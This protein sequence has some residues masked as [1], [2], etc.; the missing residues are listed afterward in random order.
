MLCP[1]IQRQTFQITGIIV[2]AVLILASVAEAQLP[3]LADTSLK[4]IPADASIYSISLR[5]E[6]TYQRLIESRAYAGLMQMP[7]VVQL[8]EQAEELLANPIAQG[9]MAD[10]ANK[11]LLALLSRLYGKESFFY[12]DQSYADLMGL[13]RD[14][15]LANSMVPIRMLAATSA[16]EKP[17]RSMQFAA[18]FR[19]AASNSDRLK[20]PNI[21]C[22]F[23]LSE[24]DVE[25]A[26]AQL[27]RLEVIGGL[28]LSGNEMLAGRLKAETVA[29]G[30]FITLSLDGS[31]LPWEEIPWDQFGAK[32]E[33]LDKLKKALREATLRVAIGVKDDYLMI[34][35]GSDMQHVEKLGK[36]DLLIDRPEFKRLTPFTDW[37]IVS[38]GYVGS[39]MMN[40][41]LMTKDYFQK[42]T[43]EVAAVLP[44]KMDP[45]LRKEI[46]K[47]IAAVEQ[48]VTEYLP[49]AGAVLGIGWS[50]AQ[51]YEGRKFNWSKNNVIVGDEPLSILSYVRGD[52]IWALTA[53]ERRTG[54]ELKMLNLFLSIAK[55]YGSKAIEMNLKGEDL[56]VYQE[57]Q[58]GADPLWQRFLRAN[59]NHLTA[60]MGTGEGAILLDAD[61]A[62][63]QW[64][65]LMP[66]AD[67][68]LPMFELAMLMEIS[69]RDGFVRGCEEYT[70]ICSDFLA[71][72]HN[73]EPDDFPEIT[74]PEPARKDL[75]EAGELYIYAAPEAWGLDEQIDT[76]LGNRRGPDNIVPGSS[77]THLEKDFAP[78]GLCGRRSRRTCSDGGRVSLG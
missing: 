66:P 60:V 64:L 75:D 18:L 54:G 26:T 23:K 16:G 78:N 49:E 72:L 35:I 1:K 41:I 2:S 33:D 32:V 8:K 31:M 74:F 62:S 29:G 69:D 9:F 25:V 4:F 76:W 51:G 47:D 53:R 19:A 67:A 58:K 61:S 37:P 21:L 59:E 39:E 77:G 17:D 38:V 30:E 10:E 71:L 57:F 43:A 13:Y 40:N 3:A 11:D 73:I 65:G 56:E 68:Q 7:V 70:Q 28:A 12:A 46:E 20:I 44:E 42:I 48:S 27:K 22:G 5:G 55:K 63:K 34:S 14:V 52:P 50:T 15:N 6:E 24:A 45:E 36:G